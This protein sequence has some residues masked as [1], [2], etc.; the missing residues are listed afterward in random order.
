MLHSIVHALDGRIAGVSNDALGESHVIT[1]HGVEGGTGLSLA[2]VVDEYADG[3][4]R[5]VE[6]GRWAHRRS[7]E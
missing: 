4:N 7:G 1:I 6:R 5:F 2:M 3:I